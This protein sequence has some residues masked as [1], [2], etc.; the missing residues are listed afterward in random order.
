MTPMEDNPTPLFAVPYADPRSSNDVQMEC[1]DGLTQN[2]TREYQRS[3][4]AHEPEER[5]CLI[6]GRCK[7]DG[8]HRDRR[9]LDDTRQ[10][11]AKTRSD[12]VGNVLPKKVALATEPRAHDHDPRAHDHDRAASIRAWSLF[13]HRLFIGVHCPDQGRPNLNAPA[14]LIVSHYHV[15]SQMR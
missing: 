6:T 3:R 4:Y 8:Q 15:L 5:R 1:K 11:H 7:H 9:P 2:R 14:C 10:R 12:K 13:A